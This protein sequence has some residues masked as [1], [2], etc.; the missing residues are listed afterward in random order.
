MPQRSRASNPSAD[1]SFWPLLHLLH[2]FER[3]R[4]S[5]AR[6]LLRFL[7]E[8]MHDTDAAFID[9]TQDARDAMLERLLRTSQRPRPSACNT[10]GP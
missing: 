7:D 8:A 9:E 3:Q 2:A 5:V 10:A 1:F 4:D 6:G